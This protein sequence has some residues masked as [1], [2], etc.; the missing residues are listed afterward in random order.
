MYMKLLRNALCLKAVFGAASFALAV[1]TCVVIAALAGCSNILFAQAP[2]IKM[3]LWEKTMTMDMGTGTP[4]KIAAKSCVSP[5]TWQ[6]MAG[7]MSKQQEGCTI[8]NVKNAHGYT[9]T[10]T[11]KTPGG[12][13]MVTNGSETIQDSEHI[14]SQSHSVMTTG[15]QKRE[16][17][18]KSTSTFLGSDCGKVKP[19]EPETEDK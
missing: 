5:A 13:T 18:S 15:A 1:D 7:N 11:C 9:F 19:G 8:N 17:D 14:S 4:R 12:G 10:A 3:G 16:M 2:P 6:E